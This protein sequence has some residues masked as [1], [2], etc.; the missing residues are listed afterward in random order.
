MDYYYNSK[1]LPINLHASARD[2]FI[3]HMD[4]I[5]PELYVNGAVEQRDYR[6]VTHADRDALLGKAA[7]PDEY[8]ADIAKVERTSQ[9]NI[10]ACSTHAGSH[11][12]QILDLSDTGRRKLSPISLWRFIK[13]FDG[14]APNVGTTMEALMK[15]L[16]KFG[17]CDWDVL[18]TDFSLSE[19][20]Q[21]Y[22][23]LT[24]EQIDNADPKRIKEKYAITYYPDQDEVR[25]IIYTDK[26]AILLVRFD[27]RWYRSDTLTENGELKYGHFVCAYGYDK[28]WIYI[29]DSSDDVYSYKKL[30]RDYKFVA[31]GSGVDLPDAYVQ[32]LIDQ[33]KILQK[34]VELYR[35]LL[36][37]MK[38]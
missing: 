19:A 14:F 2:N 29:I 25:D 34:I 35:K 32:G 22:T 27:G 11:F 31:V 4:E 10:P 16:A 21:A 30:G 24:D 12:K 15:G 18:P 23:K 36:G 17:L 6:N 26:A 8:K 5:N 37:L 1:L 28:D 33:R 20:I 13:T 7:R 3:N 9:K 38:K